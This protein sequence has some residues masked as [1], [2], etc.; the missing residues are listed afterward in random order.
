MGYLAHRGSPSLQHLHIKADGN[1]IEVVDGSY[2]S[3][4]GRARYIR[5]LHLGLV[6][7][8]LIEGPAARIAQVTRTSPLTSLSINLAHC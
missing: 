4:L 2:L 5:S 7:S 8:H 6:G 3:D 1:D